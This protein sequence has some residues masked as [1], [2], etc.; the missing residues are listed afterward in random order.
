MTVYDR[1]GLK[2]V[3]NLEVPLT[4][5]SWKSQK[6]STPDPFESLFTKG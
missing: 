5:K 6:N 3:Q 2:K 1:A 4:C